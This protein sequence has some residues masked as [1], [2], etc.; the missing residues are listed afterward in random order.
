[1][2]EGLSQAQPK[3]IR[4]AIEFAELWVHECQR[5]FSDRLICQQDQTIL[6]Q[7]IQ[8]IFE[9][10]PTIQQFNI[11]F[12]QL[13]TPG[14]HDLV[15]CS[16]SDQHPEGR[17]MGAY[18][19]VVDY[20]SLVDRI[21][22]YIQYH[23]QLNQNQLQ[24]V[25]FKDCVLNMLKIVRI[26]SLPS[27]HSLLLGSGGAGRSSLTQL[28]AFICQMELF[29]MKQSEEWREQVKKIMYAAGVENKKVVFFIKEGQIHD[30]QIMEVISRPSFLQ[31]VVHV[32][33]SSCASA[34]HRARRTRPSE[35]ARCAARGAGRRLRCIACNAL[36]FCSLTRFQ[37]ISH[38]LNNGEVPEL[39]TKEEKAKNIEEMN[40]F[41]ESKKAVKQ[42]KIILESDNESSQQPQNQNQPA[43]APPKKDAKPE[44]EQST[45]TIVTRPSRSPTQVACA[46]R[47][48]QAIIFGPS[49]MRLPVLRQSRAG[50]D[51]PTACE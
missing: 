47:H 6:L 27:G 30:E 20:K 21:A 41:L 49:A 38:I 7:Q 15:F 46:A 16:F 25:L 12:Q 45:N 33:A 36:A 40:N 1:M 13:Q 18:K 51:S 42:N 3:G 44:Q 19:P 24:L 32:G 17:E 5:V 14:V 2:C 43:T 35:R 39:Y 28:A 8:K 29:F 34:H 4:Q 11:Q 26:I 22:E 37:D 9:K 48:P 31:R 23:N 10:N 50:R